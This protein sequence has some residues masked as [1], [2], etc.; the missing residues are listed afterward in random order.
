M[1]QIQDNPGIN[2]DESCKEHS[3]Y[4]ESRHDR[5]DYGF[6]A[7]KIILS[8]TDSPQLGTLPDITPVLRCMILQTDLDQCGFILTP[9]YA[10]LPCIRRPAT[11][12]VPLPP[13]PDTHQVAICILLALLLGLYPSSIKFPP[14]SVRVNI[15]RRIH[16][17]LTNGQGISFCQSHP[18]LLTLALMEYVSYVIPTYLPV[19]HDLLSDEYNMRTFFSTCPLSCDAF[20]QE[21]LETGEES[22]DVL[23]ANCVPIVERHSRACRSRQRARQPDQYPV[24][25]LSPASIDHIQDIPFIVP[26]SIHLEDPTNCIMASEMAFLGLAQLESF[27]AQVENSAT[28]IE[29]LNS[30]PQMESRETKMDHESELSN[31][32]ESRPGIQSTGLD[33]VDIQ[34]ESMTDVTSLNDNLNPQLKLSNDNLNPQL[35][36]SNDNLNPQLKLLNDNLNPQLKLLNDNL[37]PQLKL[38]NDNLNPPLDQASTTSQIEVTESDTTKC[39]ITALAGDAISELEINLK[40]DINITKERKSLKSEIKPLKSL[41][42][43]KQSKETQEE[44]IK[45]EQAVIMQRTIHTHQLPPNLTK[46]QFSAL[47]AR[48]RV[49]ERS[50]LSGSVIYVCISCIMANQQT[51]C[52]KGKAF[53]TRGQCKFDLDSESLICSVCQSHSIISINTLGRIISIRNYR[54]YL[55]PCCCTVQIYTGRGDEFQDT[56]ATCPHKQVKTPV[57]TQKKRCE[58]C[59]NVALPEPHSSV[60]H[61]TGEQHHTHLC[62]RH[63]PHL[64]SLKHVTNWRQLQ[65]EIRNRDKPLFAIRNSGRNRRGK[66]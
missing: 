15:Y 58:L 45:H 36:L 10:A 48:M 50:A 53:P 32:I 33:N 6:I 21:A 3:Q 17:L 20:R 38:L 55:T 59:S 39:K 34:L 37:N 25:K 51:I 42:S 14:F 40:S 18:S 26:Y 4:R 61:I 49:C 23:E 27:K 30:E 44:F 11:R 41:K 54:F 35:K 19:E 8:P 66:R 22:W 63:T 9:L 65:E 60:D 12:K 13:D 24:V 31:C 64:D 47:S 1:L 2:A 62:Q 16:C 52:R 57:K 29:C 5:T 7:R 28:R 46:L 43:F 56:P